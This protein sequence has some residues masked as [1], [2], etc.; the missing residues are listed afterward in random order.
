MKHLDRLT[1]TMTA[2]VHPDERVRRMAL[3]VVET[4]ARTDFV[5][6]LRAEA[7]GCVWPSVV[8]KHE[9]TRYGTDITVTGLAF[10]CVGR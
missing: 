6:R 7:H 3:D 10:R 5:D 2:A 1:V 4:S 8:V 9:Q